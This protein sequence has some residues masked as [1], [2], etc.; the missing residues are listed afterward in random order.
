MPPNIESL[1]KNLMSGAFNYWVVNLLLTQHVFAGTRLLRFDSLEQNLFT[2]D[3]AKHRIQ[4]PEIGAPRM[5]IG[6]QS[7]LV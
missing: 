2:A 4:H 5:P 1:I 6:L 3:G 7:F